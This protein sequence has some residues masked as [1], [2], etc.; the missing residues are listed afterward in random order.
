MGIQ[1]P[2]RIIPFGG[3]SGKTCLGLGCET[4]IRLHPEAAFYQA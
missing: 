1:K 2:D 4:N 3:L